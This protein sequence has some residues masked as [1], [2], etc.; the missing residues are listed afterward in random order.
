MR[1]EKCFVCGAN[2]YPGHGS[3]Y[4]RNDAK[5][6]RFCRS[7]CRKTFQR[8]RHP[9]YLRW[10]QAYRKTHGKELAN[11][12]VF[13]FEQQRS[14]VPKYDREL[15]GQTL[16]AMKRV[17]EVQTARRTAFYRERMKVRKHVE[18]RQAE[19]EL[20]QQSMSA[21]IELVTTAA[22]ATERQAERL[23]RSSV[24]QRVRVP[25]GP[26][27]TSG[28]PAAIEDEECRTNGKREKMDVAE[29]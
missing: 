2:V 14:R 18:Q 8:K 11:D 24:R 26:S 7:K 3:L 20:A 25:A 19:R 16:A 27:D 12:L 28:I 29:E 1:I 17:E 5:M 15:V 10:T 23:A 13:D 4:V 6:F 21:N 22:T 9:R